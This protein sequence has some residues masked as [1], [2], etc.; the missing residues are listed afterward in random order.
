MAHI[1]LQAGLLSGDTRPDIGS[2]FSYL[3]VLLFS[4]PALCNEGKLENS[5]KYA[6][7]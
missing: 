3:I 5:E 2:M 7:S 6:K 4:F 1:R